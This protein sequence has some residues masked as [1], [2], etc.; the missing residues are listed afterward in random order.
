MTCLEA[1]LEL[2]LLK[3]SNASSKGEEGL[4]VTNLR[5]GALGG[6]VEFLK[7]I[8]GANLLTPASVIPKGPAGTD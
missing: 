1:Y 2:F 3:P 8:V 4:K 5:I 6:S 7:G